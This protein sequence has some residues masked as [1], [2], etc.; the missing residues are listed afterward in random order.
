M[1]NYRLTYDN[2]LKRGETISQALNRLH[3]ARQGAIKGNQSTEKIDA[4][5]SF[6]KGLNSVKPTKPAKPS[7]SKYVNYDGVSKNPMRGGGM[8]PK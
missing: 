2:V 1:K 4:K 7:G 5:I 6:L 3:R 8:S